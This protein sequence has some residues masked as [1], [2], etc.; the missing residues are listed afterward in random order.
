M[1]IGL[2]ILAAVAAV[3]FLIAALNI[4]KLGWR[5]YV[6]NLLIGI[7]QLFNA[8]MGGMPDETISSRC[9]RG[10]GKRWYWTLLGRILDAIQPG[11]IENALKSE[12]QRLQ[13]PAAL[14]K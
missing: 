8:F 3:L 14:R 9:A 6:I 13:E 10:S 12:Q 7:D 1:N 4:R 2:I 5:A 11:H